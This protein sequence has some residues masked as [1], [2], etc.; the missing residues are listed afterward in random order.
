MPF[1]ICSLTW[2][3]MKATT[4]LRHAILRAMF[5]YEIDHERDRV[6]GEACI[7]PY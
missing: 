2:P 3:G 4:S 7:F 5:A 6:D 1:S